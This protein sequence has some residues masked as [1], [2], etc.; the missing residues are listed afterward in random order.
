MVAGSPPECCR[1]FV[2]TL[3]GAEVRRVPG[4]ASS[5]VLPCEVGRYCVQCVDPQGNVSAPVCCTVDDCGACP[6][7][8]IDQ[9]LCQPDAAGQLVISWTL[10]PTP[11]QCCERFVVL[12]DGVVVATAPAGA[13]SV[14]VL[15]MPGRY[16]VV[17]IGPDGTPSEPVC[18]EVTPSMCRQRPRI[19]RGDCDGDG[20]ACTSVNDAVILLNWNFLGARRPPCLAA[21]DANADGEVRGQVGDAIYD[22]TFCF[23]GGPPPPPPFPECGELSDKDMALGCEM[24]PAVCNEGAGAG[25]E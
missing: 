9:V 2:I 24:P 23:L 20:S 13:T 12:K 22:L 1:E 4:T 25:G 14:M 11:E 17:C 21:C 5:V 18:C 10:L 8:P 7:N 15:C 16:C 3:N 19:V 6:P